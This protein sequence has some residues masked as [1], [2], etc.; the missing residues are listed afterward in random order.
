MK[1]A[2]TIIL[3]IATLFLMFDALNAGQALMMFFL[4]GVIP[5]TNHAI[6]ASQMLILF[7]LL[8]GFVIARLTLYVVR[9]RSAQ[10]VLNTSQA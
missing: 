1:K 7:A 8:A 9:T 5:G 4:A 10:E 3:T 2:L 6:G